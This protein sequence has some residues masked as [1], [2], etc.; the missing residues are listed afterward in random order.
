MLLEGTIGAREK[1]DAGANHRKEPSEA[2]ML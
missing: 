2:K 1:T